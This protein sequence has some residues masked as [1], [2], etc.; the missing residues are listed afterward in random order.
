ML[1]FEAIHDM[2]KPMVCRVYK[3]EQGAEPLTLKLVATS[4]SNNL[5]ALTGTKNPLS[6]RT[7]IFLNQ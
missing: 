6:T 2:Q 3:I 1:C 4:C 5:T 7:F